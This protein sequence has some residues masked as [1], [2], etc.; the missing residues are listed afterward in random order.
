MICFCLAK[1]HSFSSVLIP[2]VSYCIEQDSGTP[3]YLYKE[4]VLVYT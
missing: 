3:D 1:Q 2:K 4:F